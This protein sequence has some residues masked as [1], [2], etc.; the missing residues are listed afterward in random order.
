MSEAIATPGYYLHDIHQWMPLDQRDVASLALECLTIATLNVWHSP[1]F[2]HQRC[3]ATLALLASFHPDLIALQEV[4]PAFLDQVLKTPCVQAAYH[5]SDISGSSVDPYG[6]L[7]LSR[8]PIGDWQL[9][10]LPSAMG[11]HLVTA[12]ALLNGTVTT[13]ASV[14]LESF[15]HATPTRAK[16]L[17]RI[18]RHLAPDQHVILTGDFNFCSTWDENQQ[19]DPAYQDI[20]AALHPEQAGFTEDTERNTMRLLH[21]GKPKQ[22]RFD[23]MLL[24]SR[25]PGWQAEAIELIG[26]EPIAGSTPDIFPSDHFGLVSRLRWQT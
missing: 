5:I 22:V 7:L 15:S 1:D 10:A 3:H 4:S 12:H 24:R 2:F 8:F 13:F 21:T 6:V 20:W 14:H 11:R 23:R 17:A 26:T 19:L 25:P 16:Q 9:L 18:F